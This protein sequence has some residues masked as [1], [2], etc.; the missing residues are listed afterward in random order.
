MDNEAEFVISG[1]GTLLRYNGKE[2]LVIVPDGVTALGNRVFF[3]KPVAEIILP[4]TL[5][6]IGKE[7]I[8]NCHSLLKVTLSSNLQ[9]IEEEAFEFCGQLQELNGC[10]LSKVNIAENAFVGC[11]S[12]AD[13][14][15]LFILNHRVLAWDDVTTNIRIP[16]TIDYI[17]T[18]VFYYKKVNLTMSLHCPLWRPTVKNDWA[19]S[20]IS[21]GDSTISFLDSNGNVAAKIV[22]AIMG[23]SAP[24]RIKYILSIRCKEDRSFDFEA[25]DQTFSLLKDKDNKIKMAMARLQYPYELSEE[26]RNAYARSL[27]RSS[28]DAAVNSINDNDANALKFLLDH[29]Y[30]KSKHVDA[31]IKYAEENKK[32]EVVSTLLTYKQAT[33]TENSLQLNNAT[34]QDDRLY[35]SVQKGRK[36]YAFRYQNEGICITEYNG[37]ENCVTFPA[38]IG[39]KYVNSIG[40]RG[41]YYYERFSTSIRSRYRKSKVKKIVI[42]GWIQEIEE[43]SF[44]NLQ[45]IEIDFQEGIKEINMNIFGEECS[46]LKICLPGSLHSIKQSG[47]HRTRIDSQTVNF[48]VPEKSYAEHFCKKHHYSYVTTPASNGSEADFAESVINAQSVDKLKTKNKRKKEIAKNKLQ[49]KTSKLNEGLISRYLGEE[50]DVVYPEK[51][52][53]VIIKGI[54]DTT[55]KTPDN[56][57][58]I[59]TITIPE[60]Y[61]YIGKNAFAGCESLKYIH[62]PSTIREISSQ[63]FKGCSG[64]KELYLS[65]TISF[66]GN[67]IFDDAQIQTLILETGKN[68]IPN[69]LFSGAEVN[70]FVILGG[71][72]ESNSWIFDTFPN[73]V[74]I[75]GE[76]R[77]RDFTYHFDW[78]ADSFHT[79]KEFNANSINDPKIKE[80]VEKEIERAS[81]VPLYC[82]QTEKTEHI[83]Y[84]NSNF[85]I[86]GFEYNQADASVEIKVKEHIKKSGG[87]VKYDSI[88]NVNYIV[89][90]DH[91]IQYTPKTRKAMKLRANGINISIIKASDC[92]KN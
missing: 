33:K 30:V 91:P 2:K 74:Y 43:N 56:Y 17:D 90:P 8:Y 76:Y 53:D 14:S 55:G 6:T 20:L 49:W 5:K 16:D 52:G 50:K 82:V 36:L 75:N 64:L 78:S 51:I 92:L 28:L 80:R 54:A 27:K 42:P 1:D 48:I 61:Q 41:S 62:L 60:G 35:M 81:D 11:R 71:D 39:N 7:S 73:D 57:K 4:D 13:D 38:K 37:N 47:G 44:S 46:S 3:Y 67:D 45:G 86:D 85:A 32:I 10:D 79:L 66:T 72:I 77:T 70:S 63:A 69:K 15:G 88:E 18:K 25:Y 9:K 12:L 59:K 40:N 23:E 29:E 31:L 24:V 65:K 26:Y 58:H 84:K 83:D 19:S 21:S 89:V 68:R 87:K 34:Q 22:C